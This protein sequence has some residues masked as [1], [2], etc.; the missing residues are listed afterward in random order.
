MNKI[1]FTLTFLT[2]VFCLAIVFPHNASAQKRRDYLTEAEV[3]LVRDAQEIDARIAVLTRAIERRFAVLNNQT[4]KEKEEWGELP[5]GTRT[6]LLIDIEKLLDKAIDD[7]DNVAERNRESKLFP[8]AV[9]K[10]ASACTEYQPQFKTY[11]D[12]TKDEKERGALLGSIQHCTDVIEAS[13]KV[14][15]EPEKEE[16]KKKN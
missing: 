2:V 10:L 8:K 12:A 14:P 15:K 7:I 1:K 9:N 4:P 16:K 5:K 13:A 11:L 3:E 6:E